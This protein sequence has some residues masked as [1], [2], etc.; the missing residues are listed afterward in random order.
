MGQSA[1]ELRRE[2]EESRAHLGDTLEAIGDRVSPA[3]MVER[4]KNRM[5]FGARHL[6]SRVMGSAESVVDTAKDVPGMVRSE[7]EGTPMIAGGVAFGLG[8]LAAVAFPTTAAERNVAPKVAATTQPLMQ[9]LA[10][11]GK[12]M[13]DHLREPLAEA[14]TAIKDT[15][16]E[17]AHRVA[18]TVSSHTSTGSGVSS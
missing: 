5:A 17:S 8:F 12:E 10:E 9:E 7:T 11:S 16:G 2:I 18:D 3:R 15:A 13:G 14:T 4:R 6:R 1:E